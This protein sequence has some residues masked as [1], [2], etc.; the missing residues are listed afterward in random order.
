M[1]TNG[2]E[3]AATPRLE[4]Q[5]LHTSG[6]ERGPVAEPSAED[7]ALAPLVDKIAYGI[8]RGLI[9]A[10]KELEL[11]I[12]GETRKVSDAVDRRMEMLQSSMRDLSR[13]MTEQQSANAA[14]QGRFQ[15]L[16]AGLDESDARREAAV[17]A[18]RLET[19]ELSESLSQRIEAAGAALQET[20]AR[21]TAG[22]AALENA[23]S[24]RIDALSREL[25]IHQEDIGALKSAFHA[26]TSRVDVLVERLDRQA[27]AVRSMYVAYSQRESELEQL[28]DGLA[29]LRAQPAPL[30]ANAL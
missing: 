30:P 14:V 21:Q 29:R 25:S 3:Y 12:A 5:I 26:F 9:V 27:D 4:E 2:I 8:A 23:V 15:Q 13:F 19:R 20:D 10:V 6:V 7:F 1:G 16:S 22:L 28:V 11:H 17:A 18:L 24:E